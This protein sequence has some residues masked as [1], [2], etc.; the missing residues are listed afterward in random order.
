MID[1]FFVIN[2][3]V[4][5]HHRAAY[6]RRSPLQETIPFA[7][8]SYLVHPQ[9]YTRAAQGNQ[10]TPP[11]AQERKRSPTMYAVYFRKHCRT[12]FL[13]LYPRL[14]CVC[15]QLWAC[16]TQAL[17]TCYPLSRESLPVSIL[18]EITPMNLVWNH[19]SHILSDLC[20]YICVL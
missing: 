7:C 11:S 19:R 8:K 14:H 4:Y 3:L 12:D 13:L 20:L 17:T 10:K 5:C 18:C 9:C 2:V 1:N 6:V 15:R 16:S